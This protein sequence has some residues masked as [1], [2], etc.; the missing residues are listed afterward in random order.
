MRIVG[1]LD[2]YVRFRS[3]LIENEPTIKLY[4]QHLWAEL[5]DAR[6]ADVEMSLKLF[7]RL[8]ER[9][10]LLLRSMKPVDFQR[11]HVHPETGVN[12]LGPTLQM[13]AWHGKHH[14]A[15]VTSLTKRMGW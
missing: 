9:W 4:E 14:V 3:A 15:H 11:K 5:S 13:Y 6:S 2:A 10:V 12:N 7:E 1:F 8:H